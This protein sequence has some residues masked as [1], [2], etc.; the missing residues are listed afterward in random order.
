M[1]FCICNLRSAVGISPFAKRRLS[2]RSKAW[3]ID[4]LFGSGLDELESTTSPAFIAAALPKTT[5]S[6][7]EL[8]PNLLAP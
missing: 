4:S 7:K 3:S 8:E 1:V 5:R 2:K 6:I